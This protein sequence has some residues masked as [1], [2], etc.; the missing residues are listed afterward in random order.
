MMDKIK[1][2]VNK[3]LGKSEPPAPQPIDKQ[4]T[5]RKIEFAIAK[6][7]GKEKTLNKQ[8]QQTREAAKTALKKGD[9]KGYKSHSRRF[10]MLKKQL[11]TTN[12][13]QEKY[14]KMKD[15]IDLQENVSEIMEIGESLTDIQKN[16]G[17]DI[18]EIEQVAGNIR[19][20]MEEVDKAS[21]LFNTSMDVA[22]SG[23][24]ELDNDELQD[25]LLAE[26]QS[27][28]GMNEFADMDEELVE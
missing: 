28:Q 1:G 22:M 18:D 6:L 7:D 23:S 12:G 3:S 8:L 26:I 15:T 25:E 2:F 17:I 21:E 20:S 5:I 13:M 11:D 27:E 16:L 24:V 14:S 9:D 19:T 10:Q 4:K